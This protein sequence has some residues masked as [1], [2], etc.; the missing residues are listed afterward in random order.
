MAFCSPLS[1]Y[2]E[3]FLMHA[4]TIPQSILPR[5]QRRAITVNPALLTQRWRHRRTQPHKEESGPLW[6]GSDPIA[7]LLS[8][9]IRGSPRVTSGLVASGTLPDLRIHTKHHGFWGRA[10]NV[11]HLPQRVYSSHLNLKLALLWWPTSSLGVTEQSA[12]RVGVCCM[13]RDPNSERRGKNPAAAPKSTT[14]SALGL[15]GKAEPSL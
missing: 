15:H 13:A 6:P 9:D 2:L 14:G 1:R 4:S 5:I 11:M 3:Y 12:S 8:Q 7:H 10:L